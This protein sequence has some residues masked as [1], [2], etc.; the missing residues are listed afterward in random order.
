MKDELLDWKLTGYSIAYVTTFCLGVSWG[1]H[2]APKPDTAYER[3]VDN[4]K[5]LVIT[6]ETNKH[7]VMLKRETTGEYVRLEKIISEEGGDFEK[8]REN[9]RKAV[10]EQLLK[11]KP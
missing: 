8:Q 9:E 10:L 7:Y 11:S 5:Y 3:E 4:K 6:T 2:I 1:I